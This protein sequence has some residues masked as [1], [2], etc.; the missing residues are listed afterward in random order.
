MRYDVLTLFPEMFDG[1][2]GSSILKIAAEKNVVSYNCTDFRQFSKDKHRRVDDYPYGGGGGMVLTPQ[3]I[4]DAINEVTNSYQAKKAKS[5][6]TL[7]TGRA[8]YSKKG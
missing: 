7:S 1:V 2:F 5:S 6:F 4:F 3:P 8:I